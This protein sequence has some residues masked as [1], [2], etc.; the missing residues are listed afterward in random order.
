MS[1]IARKSAPKPHAG[2]SATAATVTVV[3]LQAV[4]AAGARCARVAKPMA[5]TTTNQSAESAAAPHKGWSTMR[6]G[7]RATM[8]LESVH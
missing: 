6:A 4:V 8:N 1:H 5:A 2:S 7:D 3:P